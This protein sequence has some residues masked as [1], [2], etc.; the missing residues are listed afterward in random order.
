MISNKVLHQGDNDI[1]N[2]RGMSEFVTFFGQLV[3]HTFASTPTIESERMDIRVP[4]RDKWFKGG[5]TLK[6]LKSQKFRGTPINSLSSFVDG[7]SIYGNS[8]ER[9]KSLRVFK[10][11]MMK[12]SGGGSGLGLLPKN[13]EGVENA[14]RKNAKGFFLAGDDRSNEHPMLT[15]LH[16]VFIREHNL[17]AKEV[18][19]KNKGLSD[20][21]IFQRAR[22][23]NIG[24]FQK[25]VY[26]EFLPTMMGEGALKPYRGYK[27]YINP[28]VD[29]SFTTAA[30]RVGH[31]LVNDEVSRMGA[32]GERMRGIS[33]KDAFFDPK[34]VEKNGVEVFLR[35]AA[36]T[37]TQE[38]DAKVVDGLRNFL[39]TTVEM[40]FPEVSGFDLAALNIQRGR[41]HLIGDYMGAR[42]AYGLS[43]FRRWRDLT[44]NRRLRR[45]LRRVY[46]RDI[47]NVDA[48]VGGL[49]EKHKSGSSL[50]PLFHSSWKRSF[51]RMRDA[52]YYYYEKKG[53]FTN[54][55]KKMYPRVKKLFD[56]NSKI[57]RDI[58]IRATDITESELQQN[59]FRA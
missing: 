20:E 44:R 5:K 32:G 13:L 28:D 39:F 51:E 17:I 22:K 48:W 30:F 35:A 33:L 56:S 58:L 24:Q 2:D 19:E 31:T 23:I 49:I 8:E 4:R 11:G 6:F 41:D 38:V 57:M 46:K 27:P 50:G 26:K 12:V 10:D 55:E 47:N 1:R 53:E 7:S 42:K 25:I 52:D 16:T 9:G 3:D 14:P 18:M 37:K 43:T 40:Q 45:A 36:K 59:V 21:E 54:E 29:L 34:I 15:C